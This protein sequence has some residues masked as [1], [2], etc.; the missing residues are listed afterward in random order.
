MRR[1]FQNTTAIAACLSL[2]AP[3]MAA[4][5]TAA[6]GDAQVVQPSAAD[7][8]QTTATE[9]TTSD[10][11]PVDRETAAETSSDDAV[12]AGPAAATTA[13]ET[14]TTAA[15]VEAT[16]E[17]TA[18]ATSEADPAGNE[19]TL[20]EAMA[21]EQDGTEGATTETTGVLSEAEMTATD[22]DSAID[23]TTS[24]T[25]EATSAE[26]TATGAH[27]TSDAAGAE[28]TA[29]ADAA[30][31]EAALDEAMA[32][33]QVGVEGTTP[34][35]SG[36]ASEA[37]M[38]A[39]APDS[40]V[41]ATTATDAEAAST[42]TT[43]TSPVG[44]EAE[45]DMSGA[46]TATTTATGAGETETATQ[47]E[48]AVGS[49]A[50]DTDV[51]PEAT[52][53]VSDAPTAAAL[54]DSASAEIVEEEVTEENS[55]SSNEDFA[56]TLQQATST[57][58]S[59]ERSSDNDDS[60]DLTKAILLGLGGVA[61]GAMLSNNRQVALSTSDRIV[62]TRPD[63][64]QQLIKDDVALLRQPG[65]TVATENFDDGSSRTVVMRSD[66]SRVVTIRDADLRVL[67][68]TLISAD[69]TQTILLDETL[70]VGPV[71]V[72]SLPSPAQSLGGATTDLDE[73]QLRDAL[74][75]ELAVDRRFSLTQI[76]DI[77]EVRSLVA[78]VD[79]NAVT[80]ETDSAA[81]DADQAKMLT[82]LGNVIREAIDSNPNEIFLVEGHTDTVGDPA[83][84]L[85]L[86]DRRAESVALALSEYFQ[87]PPENMVVQGYGE[88][89]PRI[90]Q[91]GDVRENR[92]A[93]VRRITDLLQTASN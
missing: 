53:E 67:R 58:G 7:A 5:Q 63:G 26:T 37:E 71:D 48:A 61:V 11:A 31:N 68:R 57:D 23:A 19:A 8:P 54:D 87:V 39:S 14:Q 6:D 73:A 21:A 13:A 12:D 84:N 89:F 25:A 80:F 27:A 30:G 69:G 24:T 91:E 35:A 93:S 41:E 29:D 51:A 86:S 20:D 28:A 60:N 49:D 66:G 92:R 52:T 17:T 83:A 36:A 46:D 50:T 70:V 34:E 2:L 64:T 62:V 38:S 56:T 1:I 10:A 42:E 22:T 40:S 59:Q 9:A 32:A 55:R 16:S 78:S 72:A 45:A 4:A 18:E 77:A 47:G 76:R 82:A 85:A 43:T 44:P 3:H 15:D 79:V 75:G 81:I 33:E 88:Q 90:L 74:M 65:S